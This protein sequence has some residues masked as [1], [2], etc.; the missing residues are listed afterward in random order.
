ME[1]KFRLAGLALAGAMVVAGT[2]AVPKAAVAKEAGDWLIRARVIAVVPDEKSKI[3]PIGGKAKLGNEVSGELDFT[4]FVTD[5][6]AAELILATTKHSVAAAGTA[7]GD[8]DLGHVWL[9]PPTLTVQYH[10]NPKGRLS[11]YLGT[12]INL[13]LHH[14]VNPGPVVAD[15]NYDTSVGFALQG[16]FDYRISRRVSFNVDIKRIWLNSDVTIDAG[17]L[18]IVK[19]NVDINP[20]II[21]TGIGITF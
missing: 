11:P 10:F 2:F 3:T 21:G 5:H 12:G 4:Y 6:V 19:A 20:F 7:I 18:G 16:G 15:V 17:P 13:T 9:L 8:I 14:S 1:E